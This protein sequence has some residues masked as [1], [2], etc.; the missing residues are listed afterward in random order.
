MDEDKKNV[1]CSFCRSKWLDEISLIAITGVF[2][3]NLS[4][5]SA[6]PNTTTRSKNAP[7]VYSWNSYGRQDLPNPLF[8]KEG[9]SNTARK[10]V[11]P[12]VPLQK[13]AELAALSEKLVELAASI[14]KSSEPAALSE[15]LIELAASLQKSSE[16]A[17]LPEKLV[18]LAAS[19]QKS[20]ESAAPAQKPAGPTALPQKL[21]ELAASLQKPAEPATPAQKPARPAALPPAHPSVKPSMSPAAFVKQTLEKFSIIKPMD[22]ASAQSRNQYSTQKYCHILKNLKALL[23][24]K[25]TRDMA[26]EFVIL[27]I[28]FTVHNA[29]SIYEQAS[30]AKMTKKPTAEQICFESLNIALEQTLPFTKDLGCFEEFTK[31]LEESYGPS[32]DIFKGEFQS[33][34]H[35][36]KNRPDDDSG[37]RT[38]F[39]Y[40]YA[41]TMEQRACAIVGRYSNLF[42]IKNCPEEIVTLLDQYAEEI[43]ESMINASKNLGTS[44]AAATLNR[45]NDE[46]ARFIVSKADAMVQK[47]PDEKIDKIYKTLAITA[48]PFVLPFISETGS[49][50]AFVNGFKS[51]GIPPLRKIF[52]IKF[53]LFGEFIVN[54]GSP[55]LDEE[56]EADQS[57]LT[58]TEKREADRRKQKEKDRREAAAQKY[59]AIQ[60]DTIIEFTCELMRIYLDIFQKRDTPNWPI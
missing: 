59:I 17:A 55:S 10:P 28:K 9:P 26:R 57:K 39:S 33:V 18:E 25:D 38:D 54:Q 41:Q 11:E 46:L 53:R 56:P 6:N 23:S 20:S 16:P 52:E 27:V 35:L 12:A 48:L 14:Q 15:K 13:S 50:W 37:I 43:K 24:G 3:A 8:W 45:T 60:T 51:G 30:Q 7:S 47:F 4:S 44:Q 5:L 21:V 32:F 40:E 1:S 58:L 2:S 42:T 29:D 36:F 19:I 34:T 31:L 49:L 22:A